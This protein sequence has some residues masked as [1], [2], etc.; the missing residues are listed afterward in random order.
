MARSAS[1]TW[2]TWQSGRAANARACDWPRPRTP[3]TAKLTADLADVPDRDRYEVVLQNDAKCILD[4]LA[5]LAGTSSSLGALLAQARTREAD[6]E[7]AR[8][9]ELDPLHALPRQQLQWREL[10][11]VKRPENSSRT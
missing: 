6:E 4:D 11:A 1:H 5:G 9:L 3:I 10:L 2:V 7:F 8:A